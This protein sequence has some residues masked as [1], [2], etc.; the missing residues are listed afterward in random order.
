[1]RSLAVIAGL[2][3]TLAGRGAMAVV[4]G[5]NVGAQDMVSLGGLAPKGI[6]NVQPV[7]HVASSTNI[8]LAFVLPLR[9]QDDLAAEIKRIYDPKSSEYRHYLTPDTFAAKYGASAVDYDTLKRYVV[10]NGF[11]VT[12]TSSNRLILDVSAPASTVERVLGV[13][14]N[15]YNQNGLLVRYP[16]SDPKVPAFIASAITSIEGLD[17]VPALRPHYVQKSPF[18]PDVITSHGSGPGGGMSPANI[19][20]A[21]GL[22]SVAQDGTGQT[23]ALFEL[24]GYSASDITAYE[25]NFGLTHTPL[26]NVLVDGFN[27]LPSGGGGVAEVTLDIELM[28]A[29][30]PNATKLMVYEAANNWSAIIDEYNRIATDNQ[31]K[32]ISSSWGLTELWVSSGTR[33]AENA[34]FQQMAAQGQTIYAAAGD[35]GA[36]DDGSTLSVDDPASQPYMCGVG[37]TRLSIS[38]NNWSSEATWSGG[39]GGIS[40]VWS[41]PSFQTGYGSSSSMR[42]VPDVSL[43]ADPNTGYSIYVGGGW[44]IYGGTSCAAPLWGA[45]TALVNQARIGAGQGYLGLANTTLYAVGASSHYTADF[46]DIADNS[47][48]GFYHAASGFDD[49]TGWGTFNAVNL[50][51]DMAGGVATQAPPTPGSFTATGVGPTQV[52]LTW[53]AS[54]GA[55]SYIIKRGLKSGGP[56]TAIATPSGTSYSDASG[57]HANTAYYYIIS[58]VG[59]GLTSSPTSEVAAMTTTGAPTGLKAKA[60]GAAEVDLTWLKP[61]GADSYVIRRS[62]TSGSGY[63]D[64][65]SSSTPSFQDT[66]ASSGTTYYYVVAAINSGGTS[67]NSSEASTA[68][69]SSAPGTLT[70][71]AL[72]AS[73]ISLSWTAS[74]GATSYYV[75]RSTRQGGPYTRVASILSATTDTDQHLAASTTYYYVVEAV[76]SGGAGSPSQEASATTA[77]MAPT[78]VHAKANGANEIDLVWTATKGADS[79]NILR[80][81]SQGG[82]YSQVGTS[83]TPSDADGSLTAA[84]QYYYVVQAMY[85]GSAS[86]NSAEVTATTTPNAPG[87]VT[88]TAA[89]A[90]VSLTWSAST[91]ATS[92][93][94]LKSLVSGGPYLK[95]GSPTS[96]SLTVGGLTPG[97][98]YYFVVTANNAGGASGYSSEASAMPLPGMTS[99]LRAKGVSS[100]EI[101]LT[102]TVSKGATGYTILRGTVQGGPYSNVGSATSGSYQD[103]GL[104]AST[105]YYYVVQSSNSGGNS[106]NS[107]EATSITLPAAPGSLSASASSATQIS[108]SWSSVTGATGYVI[109]KATVSGGPYLK[110]ASAVSTS[111]KPNASTASDSS[112]SPRR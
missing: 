100:S 37:G 26:Q 4:L 59:G 86:A 66:S 61:L 76:N 67:N 35:S 6:A 69:N 84:T 54:S 90:S 75:M 31:A 102:W 80:G 71:T 65:G 5:G 10:A 34:I 1:M 49:A 52:D 23:M 85:N 48:N 60:N 11:T 17:N 112:A 39:G 91:G 20:G 47:S 57:L 88:A 22:S 33:N 12:G 94:V 87:S 82:P 9:N 24:D 73:Q 55:S 78:A 72:N 8:S 68:T 43:D 21:Y 106:S 103:T 110:V 28:I 53:S 46:H 83:S 74:T 98:M 27:G 70:A 58:A 64:V 29:V 109:W 14:L 36:R 19:I 89:S 25:N 44:Q 40:Q 41:K 95:A 108:L 3:G 96:T 42:N 38:G 79:Y 93:T 32:Q 104:V 13:H 18:S 81:T 105:Q 15:T 92:Y 97:A 63:S 99:G 30:A 16:D 77:P 62:T 51:P 2:M 7:E 45:F 101:D 50:I 107:T 111:A 56:Y